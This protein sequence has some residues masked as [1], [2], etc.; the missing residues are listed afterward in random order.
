MVVHNYNSSY[1]TGGTDYLDFEASLGKKY[2]TLS[3]KQVKQ[4]GMGAW[5][6]W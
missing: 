2:K 1:Y 4:K 6:K 3:E 5:L